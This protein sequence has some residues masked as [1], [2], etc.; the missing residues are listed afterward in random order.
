MY[1]ILM[2][3]LM[4]LAQT[5]IAAL[6]GALVAHHIITGD[7]E[8]TLTASLLT[9]VALALPVALALALTLWQK[10][11]GRVK[12]LIA[13]QPGVHTEEQVDAI[14]KSGAVTPTILTPANTV[15]GVPKL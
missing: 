8:Q 14:V 15:P 1:P 4:A 9:H 13:L 5:G 11:K 10:Y 3:I 7:Q 6:G 2:Q 12:L